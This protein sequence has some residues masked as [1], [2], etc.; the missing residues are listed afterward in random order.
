MGI[1]MIK[2]CLHL[3]FSQSSTAQKSSASIFWSPAFAAFVGPQLLIFSANKP[4][5]LYSQQPS[6]TNNTN[7]TKNTTSPKRK[8][9]KRAH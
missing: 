7:I 1:N 2:Q 5:F 9:L 3:P 4:F 6:R 8:S